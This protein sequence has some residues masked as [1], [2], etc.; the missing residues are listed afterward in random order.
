MLTEHGTRIA[1]ST[2]YAAIKRGV[3][4]RE[5]SDRKM[6]DIIKTIHKANFSVYGVRKMWK[7]L[8][9]EGHEIGRDRVG[10]LMRAA[11]LRGV[12]RG[13]HKT[14]TTRRDDLAA[15]FPDRVKRQWNTGVQD[16]IWVADF[17]YVWTYAGFC[18]VSFV[19]DAAS[20]RIL[21]W[22]ASMSKETPLVTDALQQAL[23]V[24]RRTDS[25]F[26]ATGLIHHSDAGSQYTSVMLTEHLVA[27]GMEG[28]I[29]TVG[30]AYDNALMESTIGLYKTELID[31]DRFTT[32]KSRQH[33]ES[34]TARWV[35]W[36]NTER[37]HTSIG[38]IPPTEFETTHQ[39]TCIL[40]TQ[41]A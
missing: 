29:G 21:G 1:P 11:G 13:G 32:W 30:D 6:I 5:L 25:E 33:V 39:Q 8:L 2:Y 23:S 35:H 40:S 14:F 4:K 37:L 26:T 17:T 9:R 19:T 18:Y 28:S 36:Y 27:A 34:E 20:R 16:R 10:R 22:K 15:R 41:T 3:S 38:D 12:L 31:F 7:K 24:R